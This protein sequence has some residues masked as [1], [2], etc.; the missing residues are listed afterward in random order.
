VESPEKD[1]FD[2]EDAEE[3]GHAGALSAGKNQAGQT[4]EVLI[5]LDRPG[6]DAEAAKMVDV[7][8]DAPLEVQDADGAGRG[9]GL[10]SYGTHGFRLAPR[11]QPLPARS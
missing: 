7:F 10:F 2:R 4:F 5:S 8:A 6:F 1:L 3:A 11:Y 9:G